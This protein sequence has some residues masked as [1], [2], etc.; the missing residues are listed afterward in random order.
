LSEPK[1]ETSEL[2][3]VIDITSFTS[4]G[5]IGSSAFEGGRVDI[6]FDDADNGLTLSERM[7]SKTGTE[8]GSRVSIFAEDDL[9]IQSFEGVVVA[10][11]DRPR[12]SNSKLYYFVG[13]KGGAIIRLRK[14]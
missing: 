8:T 3:L 4:G 12:F 13:R 5:F 11:S 1:S 10:I 7:C 2:V 6:E 9:K 14:A